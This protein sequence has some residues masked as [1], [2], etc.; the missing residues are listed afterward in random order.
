MKQQKI[1]T[2]KKNGLINQL[3]TTKYNPNAASLLL[4]TDERSKI[5]YDSK[6]LCMWVFPFCMFLSFSN[7][8][9][10]YVEGI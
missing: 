4:K 1:D 2:A 6:L 3:D 7:N 10:Q 8:I 5:V 9:L